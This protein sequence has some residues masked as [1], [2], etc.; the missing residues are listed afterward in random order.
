MRSVRVDVLSPEAVEEALLSTFSPV[1][2][3]QLY[4]LAHRE[5]AVD[6]SLYT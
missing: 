6:E 3:I 2:R 5:R 4:A 1:P